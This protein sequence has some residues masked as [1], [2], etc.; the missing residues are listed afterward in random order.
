MLGTLASSRRIPE[1]T[2]QTNCVAMS[3][4]SGFGTG[5]GVGLGVGVVA[6][7]EG[8]A[9]DASGVGGGPITDG[10][11]RVGSGEGEGTASGTDGV[12]GA[13]PGDAGVQPAAS[14]NINNKGTAIAFI[15]LSLDR[16]ADLK[17]EYTYKR[18]SHI[19]F[20]FVFPGR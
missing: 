9:G 19:D 8:V 15:L 18:V 10:D 5:V 11:A 14:N 20:I 2:V 4:L 13:V 6:R 7:E 16:L 12:A 1:S 3:L 17:R